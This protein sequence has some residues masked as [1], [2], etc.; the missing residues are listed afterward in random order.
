M[1]KSFK[2][3]FKGILACLKGERNMRIHAAVAVYVIIAAAA[4]KISSVEWIAVIL[5]VGIVPMAEM[6]NTAIEKLG[7]AVE[8]KYSKEIGLIKDIAAGAVL[9]FSAASAV[10]GGLIFF[11]AERVQNVLS[12][13][14]NNIPVA[15]L[16]AASVPAAVYFVCRSY[17]E[18]K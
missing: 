18:K 7:D 14:Q 6:F 12:F 1:L 16:I 9:V 15:A 10:V 3:A 17:K 13:A 2:N 8:K 5:C 11:R 4:A